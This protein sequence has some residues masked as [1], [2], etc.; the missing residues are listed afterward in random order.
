MDINLQDNASFTANSGITSFAVTCKAG[1]AFHPPQFIG[2]MLRGALGHA[3][4]RNFCRCNTS[5]HRPDCFYVHLF[6]GYR[7]NKQDGL[8]ALLFTAPASNR[9]L[10][11]GDA[12]QFKLHMIG[13]SP[14]L[15]QVIL[16]CLQKALENGLGRAR[17]SFSLIAAV[18]VLQTLNLNQASVGIALTTPWL[19]KRKGEILKAENFQLHDLL[20][21][22]AQRQMLVEQ[23]FALGLTIPAKKDLLAIADRIEVRSALCDMHWQRYSQRQGSRHPLSGVHGILQLSRLSVEA[24]ACLGPLLANGTVLHGGGKTS[25]GL[26]GLAVKPRSLQLD[27][28][29]TRPLKMTALVASA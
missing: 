5:N 26:G 18:P 2:S 28:S 14:T 12:L 11:P 3:L 20:V 21:A 10:K 1:S 25:F 8:P 23:H 7:R 22:L 16:T 24:V 29:T 15:Q 6:E 27:K 19:V 13:L 9:E 17:C 4:L